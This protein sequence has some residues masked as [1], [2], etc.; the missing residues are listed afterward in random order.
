MSVD[1]SSSV[2]TKKRAARFPNID[3]AA[4]TI[5]CRESASRMERRTC[6][7][8]S[9][10]TFPTGAAPYDFRTP[11]GGLEWDDDGPPTEKT[12]APVDLEDTVLMTRDI[13]A[14][15]TLPMGTAT[16]SFMP[17]WLDKD[18]IA[19]ELCQEP[20]ETLPPQWS[21]PRMPK[22]LLSTGPSPLWGLPFTRDVC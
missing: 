1:S 21:P 4:P 6:G 14:E 5:P 22:W 19:E 20:R 12:S 13:L 17:D 9:M 11:A 7:P 10:P 8:S 16:S 3:S 18:A 15:H 2:P